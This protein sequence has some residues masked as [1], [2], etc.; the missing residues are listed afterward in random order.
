[1]LRIANHVARNSSGANGE[2]G[3]MAMCLCEA[4]V[5]VKQADAEPTG[6]YRDNRTALLVR[7]I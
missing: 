7:L 1:M 4:L 5:V 3:I 2:N 6:R